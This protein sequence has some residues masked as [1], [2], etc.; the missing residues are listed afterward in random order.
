MSREVLLN[1][2]GC[3]GERVT[4][5]LTKATRVKT[6][7]FI[8]PFFKQTRLVG[9]PFLERLNRRLMRQR[10]QRNAVVVGL[11]VLKPPKTDLRGAFPLALG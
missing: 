9:L 5:T 3:A 6:R 1:S 4:E 11:E 10:S 7:L 8:H 2:P